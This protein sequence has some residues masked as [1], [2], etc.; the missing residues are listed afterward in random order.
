MGYLLV[1]PEVLESK[2]IKYFERMPD[3]RAIA[4]FSMLRVIGSTEDVQIVSSAEEL[5][6]MIEDQ[7]AS[8]QYETV[9]TESG[10]QE[11]DG[12][13]DEIVVSDMEEGGES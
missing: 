9:D 7:K 2:G 3:G 4:D 6:K 8:G 5:K 12:I 1:K 10:T 13:I 11:T